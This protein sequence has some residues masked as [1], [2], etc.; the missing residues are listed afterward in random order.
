MS[1]ETVGK[2]GTSTVLYL[3]IATSALFFM[4]V[5]KYTGDTLCFAM[6]GIGAVSLS[7]GTVY[8]VRRRPALFRSVLFFDI[9]FILMPLFSIQ[10]R[11]LEISFPGVHYAA[12]VLLYAAIVFCS[13]RLRRTVAWLAAGRFDA[14]SAALTGA[15]IALSAAGLIGWAFGLGPELDRFLAMLPEWSKPALLLGGLGFSVSNSIVEELAFRGVLTD[16]LTVLLGCPGAVILIQ[17]VLFGLWHWEGFP[18]GTIGVTMVFVWGIF[19]GILRTRSGGMIAPIAGHIFAD[20]T[21]FFILFSIT[22]A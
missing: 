20:L 21:V 16:G 4:Y 5:E 9:M 10:D 13:P 19:L 22:G 1:T 11:V 15:M 8:L 3:F 14:V 18:G 2:G 12:V 6:Y 7:V 17:A